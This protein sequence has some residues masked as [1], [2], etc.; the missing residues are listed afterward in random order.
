MKVAVS[1][2]GE[3]LSAGFQP[4]FGR[5]PWFIIVDLETGG[6]TPLSNRHNLSGGR[7]VGVRTAQ[8]VAAS[9]AEAVLTGQIGPKAFAY[10]RGKNIQIYLTEQET[11]QEAIQTLRSGQLQP[12]DS[13][14]GEP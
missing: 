13:L 4:G 3:D 6:S 1:A 12:R 11:V 14:L 8:D 10:L 5:A 9:G 7:G 2:Q